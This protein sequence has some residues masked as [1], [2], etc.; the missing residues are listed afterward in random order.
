MKL[1]EFAASIPEGKETQ[2]GYVHLAHATQY[3]IRLQND[4]LEDRCDAEVYIDGQ[5][6]GIWRVDYK[7]TATLERPVHDTGR[8]TF[9]EVGT[10]EASKAGIRD[11]SATGL[12]RVLFKPEKRRDLIL[13]AAAPYAGGTGL[14]GHSDQKFTSVAKLDYDE[15]RF[16]TINLRLVS[17]SNEPRPLF[18]SSTPVPPPVPRRA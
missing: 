15:T 6:V 17:V 8:F 5:L 11:G 16:V 10:P 7:S 4:S 3:T 2:D 14:S 12:I 18:P 1:K 9:Y 13:S